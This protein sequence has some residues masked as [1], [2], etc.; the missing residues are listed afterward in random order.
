MYNI[1]NYAN[2][3]FSHLKSEKVQ[4]LLDMFVGSKLSS[5]IVVQIYLSVKIDEKKRKLFSC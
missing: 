2:H 3:A 1:K 5:Y 4:F